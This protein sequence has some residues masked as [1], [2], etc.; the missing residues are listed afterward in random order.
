MNATLLPTEL[1]R[2]VSEEAVL[3]PTSERTR[4]GQAYKNAYADVL[5]TLLRHTHGFNVHAPSVLLRLWKYLQGIQ[6]ESK[7]TVLPP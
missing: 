7:A 5:V 6:Q 4:S 2:Q 3:A 1:P